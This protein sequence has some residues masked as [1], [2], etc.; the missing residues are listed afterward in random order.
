MT[1]AIVTPSFVRTDHRGILTEVLNR[2][3]WESIL[4]GDM[5]PGAVMGNHYHKITRVFFFVIKGSVSVRTLHAETGARD[6]FDLRDGEGVLLHPNE[7]HAM[8]F[9][10]QTQFLM[11]KSHHYDP[12]NPDT[13]ALKV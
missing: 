8:T 3:R 11:L 10:T 6:V 5:S 2:G 12:S 1:H 4:T 13:Y 9:L 7:S